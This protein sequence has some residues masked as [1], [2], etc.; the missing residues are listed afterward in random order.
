MKYIEHIKSI[1]LLF[2][3]ILSLILTFLIWTYTPNLQIIEESQVNQLMVGKQKKLYEVIKPYRIL[4]RE[5]GEWTGT[6]GSSTI[7][8]ITEQMISWKGSEL[9]FNEMNL[10]NQQ[11]NEFLRT[12]NRMTF[13]YSEEIPLKVF[14]FIIPLTEDELPEATFDR[15]VIDWNDVSRNS[16]TI[17]FLSE[18]HRTLYS[19]EMKIYEN[20]FNSAVLQTL[21]DLK[22]YEEIERSN[23][24]SLY[25]PSEEI[26]LN[27]Y[28]YYIDEIQPDTFRDI[29]FYDPAIVRKNVDSQD[30]LKYTDGMTLMTVDIKYRN[31]NYVN[32]SSES[33]IELPSSR[34]LMDSFEFIND[35]GGFTGDYRLISMNVSKHITEYQLYKHGFP[36]FS[37]VTSTRIST[38]WGENQLFRYKRPYYLLDMDITSEKVRRE[39][40]TGLEVIEFIEKMDKLQLEHIDD[41]ILGYHLKQND[42]NLL[43][44]LEP[45][46]F[47]VSQ[48]SWIRLTPEVLGGG[49]NGLE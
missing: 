47:A 27:Q 36:V 45:S 11:L 18:Q 40:A 26:E 23:K 15:L 30:S 46:W 32:P 48:G 39:V 20:Y 16:I 4:V 35:H 7:N 31:L 44:T 19:T 10:S 17:Y 34:L 43:F 49:N 9:V 12:D 25:V 14:Q 8:D 6:V 22:V 3:V 24:L 28:T 29:L 33:M 5:N 37:A 41:I 13:F 21:K 2:L 38:T 1:I 42:N